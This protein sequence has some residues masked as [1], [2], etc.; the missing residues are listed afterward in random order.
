M[1]T[2]APNITRLIDKLVQKKLV[3]RCD[4]DH[5]RRVV[6]VAATERALEA[7]ARL[8]EPVQELHRRL[9]GGLSRAEQRELIRLLEK[10]REGT[11]APSE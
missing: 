10:C 3:S 2:R 9:T 6:Y 5:D 1:I 11:E 7:L 4:H 8:D